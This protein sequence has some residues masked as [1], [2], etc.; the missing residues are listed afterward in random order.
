MT[1][2]ADA[3]ADP[4]GGALL[5]GSARVSFHRTLRLPDDG[6]T[7]PLPPGFG[8]FPLRR[9][10]DLGSRRPASWG[11]DD[12][13]LPMYP[14]EALWL[15][16]STADDVPRAV[17][18]GVGGVDAV[19]GLPWR[20]RPGGLGP[21]GVEQNYLLVPDQPWLDG[22]L[23]GPG[24]VRQ[25]VAVERGAGRAVDEQVPDA[26]DAPGLHLR[27]YALRPEVPVRPRAVSRGLAM[28]S[29]LDLGLGAGGRM[30]QRVH[31]DPYG[32]EAWDP[33]TE[34]AAGVHLV[35]PELWAHLTGEP[36][37]PTPVD[38]RA[39]SEAGLPWFT[40]EDGPDAATLDGG[41]PLSE[42]VGVR[43]VEGEDAE[44]PV[45][46]DPAQVH[47]LRPDP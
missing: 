45:E 46:L 5:L 15:G 36:A 22:I 39:Y 2:G 14:R 26:D 18:V 17:Q 30:G 44:E 42:V 35:L 41:G 12:H 9:A 47:P 27:A 10:G 20:L 1:S 37:P 32:P 29:G 7:Y 4:E 23:V 24:T 28:A 43:E 33:G 8:R 31:A 16:L 40:W 13:Y 6:R 21:G 3:R 34:I 19:A 38:A 25:F 11:P